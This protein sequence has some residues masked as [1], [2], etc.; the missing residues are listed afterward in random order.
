MADV[1]V[2][3]RNLTKHFTV[4]TDLLGRPISV[5][6]AVDDVSF[7]IYKGE[8]FGLV[9]E[10]GCGKTTIGKMK[11]NLYQPTSGSIIFEGKDITSLNKKKSF[12]NLLYTYNYSIFLTVK[13][14]TVEHPTY[15]GDH[16][17]VILSSFL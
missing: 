5:L 9:G 13:F 6:K 12:Y 17:T 3:V 16:G 1:L 15:I 4:E 2:E 10:S 11:A 8:A 7:K 14:Y